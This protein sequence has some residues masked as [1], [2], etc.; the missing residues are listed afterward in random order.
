MIG[1]SSST[2]TRVCMKANLWL[3]L[4]LLLPSA[5]RADEFTQ[6]IRPFLAK[7]CFSCHGAKLQKGNLRLDT[8]TNEF[9]DAAKSASWTEVMDRINSGEMPPR[10]ASPR[11]SG[12]E[13]LSV[14]E[15]ISKQ[16]HAADQARLEST[17]VMR[18]L[19]RDEYARTIADLFDLPSVSYFPVWSSGP[20]T[21]S[22]SGRF[23]AQKKS[24]ADHRRSSCERLGIG[25]V[26]G[27]RP[28]DPMFFKGTV[29][30]ER[31]TRML[32]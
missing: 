17:R 27:Q 2:D 29:R 24:A 9:A 13:V 23:V 4:C 22:G 26:G 12:K 3:L 7:Y 16:I 15:W 28:A 5:V 8:L 19:N 30:E 10:K 14:A 25:P 11:P 1:I 31:W 21:S 20:P 6:D 32:S 18:R